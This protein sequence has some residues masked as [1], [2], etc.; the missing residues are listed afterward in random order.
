M[1]NFGGGNSKGGGGGQDIVQRQKSAS[2]SRNKTQT[3]TNDT[4]DDNNNNST[5]SPK[6]YVAPTATKKK[7]DVFTGVSNTEV[8]SSGSGNFGTSFFSNA[9][10]SVN[11]QQFVAGLGEGATKDDLISGILG[12]DAGIYKGAQ[13]FGEKGVDATVLANL[14]LDAGVVPTDGRV[15]AQAFAPNISGGDPGVGLQG[16]GAKMMG[17]EGQVIGADG[18]PSEFEAIPTEVANSDLVNPD[19][20]MALPGQ[21]V[22][23]DQAYNMPTGMGAQGFYPNSSKAYQYQT[24]P[25]AGRMMNSRTGFGKGLF[26]G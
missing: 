13:P 22:I 26:R 1:G 9:R 20:T 4:N 19:E 10:P 12:G 16:F 21:A 8:E 5:I 23:T 24:N 6:T 2:N 11:Q 15:E 18:V 7:P 25:F 14:G 3:H 17:G